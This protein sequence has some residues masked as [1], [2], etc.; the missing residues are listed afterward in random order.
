MDSGY[1]TS[2]VGMLDGYNIENNVSNNL[3]NMQTPGYKERSA[4]LQDFTRVLY[5]TQQQMGLSPQPVATPIGNFGLAPVIDHY[6]LNLEQGSPHYTGNPLDLM[7][8]GNAFFRV[9][10]GGHTLLTR[11]GSLQRSSTGLLVTSEGYSV[12]GRNGL[13]IKT[14]PG[15]VTVTQSGEVLVDSKRVGQLSLARVP[16]GRP[17]AE[18]S[19]GYFQGPGQTLPANAP[20]VGVLQG[21]LESSNVDLSSEMST[22]MSA[23]RAYESNSRMLQIQDNTMS[24]AVNDLGKAAS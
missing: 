16:V 22:M 2:A 8:V 18:S 23:Q 1:F 9:R 7:I 20:A 21:Y 12:L 11:N 24:L 6:G 15:T 13:P 19:G 17:L 14:P 4:V 5:N 3:A 10:A